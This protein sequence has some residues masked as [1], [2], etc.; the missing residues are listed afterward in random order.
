MVISVKHTQILLKLRTF[1]REEHSST[2]GRVNENP[3][4]FPSSFSVFSA[5]ILD[6]TDLKSGYTTSSIKL[7]W[8]K[9]I[10]T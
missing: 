5:E 2:L 1:I 9:Q 4:V 3:E 8:Y 7:Y 6:R 10:T